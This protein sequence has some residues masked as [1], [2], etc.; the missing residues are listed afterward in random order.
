MVKYENLKEDL[1]KKLKDEYKEKKKD[2]ENEIENLKAN[3]YRKKCAEKLKTKKINNIKESL[4]ERQQQ[5]IKNAEKLEKALNKSKESNNL[6]SQNKSFATDKNIKTNQNLDTSI[7]NKVLK[8]SPKTTFLKQKT[9]QD[10]LMP[11]D[12]QSKKI[13]DFNNNK[14][15]NLTGQILSPNQTLYENGLLTQSNSKS[16]NSPLNINNSVNLMEIN[17]LLK[18][19]SNNN[20]KDNFNSS[21]KEKHL[22]SYNNDDKN[23]FKERL[24]DIAPKSPSKIVAFKSLNSNKFVDNND[25]KNNNLEQ[26]NEKD[27]KL[28]EDYNQERNNKN[29]TNNYKNDFPVKLV[30]KPEKSNNESK[31]LMINPNIPLGL[32][33]FGKFLI[34]HIEQEENYK[35]L[36]EKEEKKLK[37]K[38]AKVFEKNGASDHCLLDYMTELWEKLEVSYTNRYQILNSISD[39]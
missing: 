16:L 29:E 18:T 33:E 32:Q 38:I 7:Y 17:R 10:N 34:K 2:L 13:D 23:S 19:T 21:F 12:F 4:L 1:E 35:V 14:H 8:T 15:T 11:K 9:F 36:Y 6:K 25:N 22:L 37:L 27:I 39:K 30:E 31:S 5:Q 28:N 24:K 20:N 3:L 26:I